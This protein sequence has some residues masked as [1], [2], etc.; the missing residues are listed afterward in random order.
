MVTKEKIVNIVKKFT[1]GI[2]FFILLIVIINC[3]NGNIQFKLSNDVYFAGLGFINSEIRYDSTRFECEDKEYPLA[4]IFKNNTFRQIGNIS[5]SIIAKLPGHTTNLVSGPFHISGNRT[6][7]KIIDKFDEGGICSRI[8]ELSTPENP[9][10]LIWDIKIN[11]VK[12]D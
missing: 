6:S 12:F 3:L 7:D 10:N 9:V 8:P 5:F 4:I 11:S 1:I 2:I